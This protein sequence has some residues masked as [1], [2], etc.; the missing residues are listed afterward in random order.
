M[1]LIRPVAEREV[2]PALRRALD[3]GPAIAPLPADD[4]SATLAMIRPDEP[5]EVADLAAVVATSGS[6]GVPKGILLSRTAITTAVHATHDRLGEAGDW[7]LALPGHYVAGLMVIART[8][9]AQ[10]T[11]HRAAADLHDLPDIG[12]AQRRPHYLSLV[13]TQLVRALDRPDV[14]ARLARYDAIL[15][16][17]AAADDAVLVRARR[18]GLRIVTTYGMSETCGG[19][20]YDSVPLTGV[21]VRP[22]ADERLLISGPVLFS[23]YRL[24]PDLTAAALT[25]DGHFRTGDR[26]SVDAAGRVSVA[27]RI[28]DVVV[29]G[30]VNVDLAAVERTV[31]E[32]AGRLRGRPVDVAV[33]GVPDLEWGTRVVAVSEAPLT[34]DEL[35]TQLTGALLPRQVEVLASLPRTSSGK[36]DRQALLARLT[37]GP[38][39]QPRKGLHDHDG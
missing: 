36:V 38:T 19:C 12:G 14:T 3:A 39:P 21:Q 20:V 5:A 32:I 31:R 26:G 28:D 33:I 8:I 18:A 30:G 34:R 13:P 7:T 27:G 24:R 11:L 2:V 17:G 4:S 25:D 16:G 6:T 15:L 22:D 23:G 9:V 35:G 37:D 29:S 10:T 1:S